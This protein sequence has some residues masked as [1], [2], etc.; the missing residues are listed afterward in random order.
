MENDLFVDITNASKP[1]GRT[2]EDEHIIVNPHDFQYLYRYDKYVDRRFGFIHKYSWAIPT[3]EAILEI[4]NYIGKEKVLEVCAGTGLWS[5]LLQKEGVD[6]LATDTYEETEY[7]SDYPYDSRILQAEKKFTT[8]EKLEAIEAI[9]KH[10][11]RSILFICWS[12]M[13]PLEHFK[14]TKIVY[15]G[16]QE[17]GCTGGYPGLYK[18]VWENVKTVDI[19]NWVGLKDKV[20]FFERKTTP[21]TTA[22]TTTTTTTTTPTTTTTTTTT[23]TPTTTTTTTPTTTTTIPTTTTTTPTTTTTTPTPTTTTTTTPTN[24]N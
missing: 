12:R 23:T 3:K 16:E 5:Y 21:T 9:K 2:K 13:D 10:S 7:I 20:Y 8:V 17:N 19:P 1:V 18:D 11:D 14:G 6:I 4:K 22:T 24:S 15:V